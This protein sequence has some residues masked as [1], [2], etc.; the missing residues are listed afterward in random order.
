MSTPDFGLNDMSFISAYWGKAQPQGQV[1]YPA[2]HPVAYHNLDVA[3][4]G[5]AILDT[6]PLLLKRIAA[7][8]GLPDEVA[9]TWLLFALAMHDLGKFGCCFQC[10]VEEHWAGTNRAFWVAR[11]NYPHEMHHGAVGHLL[12]HDG[13]ADKVSD[14]AGFDWDARDGL[15]SWLETVFGHHGRPVEVDKHRGKL[16]WIKPADIT[17]D[18]NLDP[19][20]PNRDPVVALDFPRPDWN[21]AV[22]EFLIGLMTCALAPEDDRQWSEHWKSPPSP[23]RL[24]EALERLAF[25]FNLDGDGPRAFQDFDLREGT[26]FPIRKL[27]IDGPGEN[28]EKFNK[29]HFFKR[30]DITKLSLPLA[31]CAL[32]TTQYYTAG[33]GSG[34][35]SSLRKRGSLSV[36]IKPANSSYWHQI[37]SNSPKLSWAPSYETASAAW[38]RIFPW[39]A[40]IQNSSGGKITG[41]DE[42]HHELLPFFATPLCLR[43]TFS[44]DPEMNSVSNNG[45][46]SVSSFF[47]TTHGAFYR[48]WRHHLS[49]YH[50]DPGKDGFNNPVQVLSQIDR[51]RDWIGIWGQNRN[52][53][54]AQTI[55]TWHHRQR[56]FY[57]QCSTTQIQGHGFYMHPTENAKVLAWVEG[58][59]PLY[60]L[61]ADRENDFYGTCKNLVLGAS[62]AAGAIVMAIKIARSTDGKEVGREQVERF[63]RQT[64]SEFRRLLQ[65][66]VGGDDPADGNEELR[67]GWLRTIKIAALRI[68]DDDIAPDD[69]WGEDPKRLVYARSELASK[70]RVKYHGDKTKGLVWDALGLHPLIKPPRGGA[71]SGARP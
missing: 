19:N 6:K 70:F 39:L 33:L 7:L 51:Y 32:I 31:T 25:A 71:S 3:A 55:K 69:V 34:H 48:G 43:L 35:R 16:V 52:I 20:D 13:I 60:L 17:S 30:G 61:A 54:P 27:F 40:S 11:G 14:A 24:S 53:S 2:S 67:K 46:R 8:A 29:D 42:G 38:P 44:D 18:L 4:A 47:A 45:G 63:W 58:S 9:R 59:A 62:E 22:T 36:L 66:L 12:W 1:G 15:A 50:E 49:H 28:T 65:E 56:R 57:I 68:F 23:E 41:P 64:E 21:A 5:A 37:W 26:S 10:V